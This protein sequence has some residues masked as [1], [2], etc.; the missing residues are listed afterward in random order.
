MP[1]SR[2][3]QE[4][5]QKMKSSY[6]SVAQAVASKSTKDGYTFIYNDDSATKILNE[7]ESN[8]DYIKN[9]ID[10]SNFPADRHKVAAFMIG[11]TM[12]HFP[13]K[14]KENLNK[15][16]N[17]DVENLV[18]LSLSVAFA[19]HILSSFYIE[20]KKEKLNLKFPIT[21]NGSEYKDSLV[22][23][24][25]LLNQHIDDNQQNRIFLL[26]ISHILYLLEEHSKLK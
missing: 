19:N 10:D 1:L 12:K 4:K 20:E 24:I 9:I 7:Y 14:L 6:I 25:S 17:E 22:A 2:E 11:A 26:S 21:S 16:K 3:E 15:T 23:L 5:L 18:N 8:R 13:I